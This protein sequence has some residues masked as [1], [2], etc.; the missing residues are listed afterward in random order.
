[1]NAPAAHDRA[2]PTHALGTLAIASA[3]YYAVAV[4]ILHVVQRDL[5]PIDRFMSDY[6]LGRA[7]F[8]MTTTF[9]V[10][11]VGLASIAVALPRVLAS[12]RS[13][14]VGLVL[15]WLGVV[16]ILGAGFFATDP[17]D[18]VTTSGKIHVLSSLLGLPALGIGL[19]LVSLGFRRDERWRSIAPLAVTLAL[20]FLAGFLSIM[21]VFAGGRGSGAAQRATIGVALVWMVVVGYRI[22]A[23]GRHLPSTPF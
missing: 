7:G 2:P 10:W 12:S 18:P 21:F 6:V 17:G 11:A 4:L 8:L 23:R 3:V 16:G 14:K 1:M 22:A 9:F 13:R 15:L 19:L 5:N 20:A